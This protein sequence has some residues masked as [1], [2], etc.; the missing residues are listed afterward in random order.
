MVAALNPIAD[1]QPDIPAHWSVTFAVDD[2]DAMA[3]K[4]AELGG[5]VV[6]AAVRRPLGQDDRH[7]R[8]AGRDV[9]REQVRP[10]EQGPRQPGRFEGPG[11]IGKRLGE[12]GI[13]PPRPLQISGLCPP[14]DR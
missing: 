12:A 11:R 13:G 14:L 5:K 8:P 1:D 9:H 4:A 3:A 2:A 7:R 10:R 6:V